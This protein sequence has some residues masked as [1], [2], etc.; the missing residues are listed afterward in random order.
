VSVS[1]FP[2]PTHRLIPSQFP[3]IE[4]FDTVATAEDLE[5]VMELAGWTNDRLAAGRINRLPRTEWVYGRSN[6]SIVMASFLHVAPS[7][8]RFNNSDLGGWYAASSLKTAM[9]EVA[10]HLRREAVDRRR[11]NIQRQFR[12]YTADLAGSYLDLRGKQAAYPEAYASDSYTGSQILGESIRASGNAGIIYD[13]LRE[14]GGINIVA[15]RPRN[16]LNVVQADHYA[17]EV[18]SSSTQIIVKKLLSSTG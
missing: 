14:L 7:G 13:S 5:A 4:L 11:A 17:I 10:H 9:V 8:S 1:S 3:P 6:A 18:Q 2:G 15:Y 16:V 12:Q